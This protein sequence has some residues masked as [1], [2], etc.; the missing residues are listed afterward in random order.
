MYAQAYTAYTATRPLSPK[1]IYFTVVRIGNG[2]NF[3]HTRTQTRRSLLDPSSIHML[4]PVGQVRNAI[5]RPKATDTHVYLR[6]F[7]NDNPD[8]HELVKCQFRLS[9]LPY[10]SCVQELQAYPGA[11]RRHHIAAETTFRPGFWSGRSYVPWLVHI[12]PGRL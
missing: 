4:H 3:P 1:Y 12:H 9:Q 10:S 11:D 5:Q 7:G 2:E 8:Y 6:N